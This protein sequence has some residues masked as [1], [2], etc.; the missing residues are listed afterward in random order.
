MQLLH[1]VRSSAA[2]S[3][4]L[5]VALADCTASSRMRCRLLPTRRARLQPSA[6]ARC[7]RWRCGSLVQAADLRGE[8][9]G[10]GEAGGVVFRAVDAQAGGQALQRGRQLVAGCRQVALSVQ[11][12]H[13]GVDDSAMKLTPGDYFAVDPVPVCISALTA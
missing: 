3:E 5:L 7:R 1:F 4:A 10:D 8:A 2:R 6:P 13:V 12:Q 11:R 9:L